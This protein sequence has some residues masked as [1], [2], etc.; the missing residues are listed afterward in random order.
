MAAVYG[1]AFCRVKRGAGA[2]P[3]DSQ[4][5]AAKPNIK[6]Q[7]DSPRRP[8]EERVGGQIDE[9]QLWA[10]SCYEECARDFA[11]K[12]LGECAARRK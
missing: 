5:G 1:P 9:A 7:M 6:D 3:F 2:L 8:G 10:E 4:K 11:A 12:P